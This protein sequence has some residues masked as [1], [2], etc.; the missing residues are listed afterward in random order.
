MSIRGVWVIL[1]YSDHPPSVL[2][3]RR[4]PNIE[5]RALKYSSKPFPHFPVPSDKDMCNAVMQEVGSVRENDLSQTTIRSCDKNWSKPV[6]ELFEGRLWPVVLI[7]QKNIYFVT[8]P[9][10]QHK[11][12]EE[13]PIPIEIPSIPV[14]LELLISMAQILSNSP[15]K[16]KV[17]GPFLSSLHQFLSISVPMGTILETNVNT[18]SSYVPVL[19]EQTLP[20][21]LPDL[22]SWK[23]VVFKGNPK[24]TLKIAEKVQL[25]QW[26][27][28]RS[29]TFWNTY[30]TV[31]CKTELEGVPEI[32]L[33]LV[34]PQG[35]FGLRTIH[36]HPSV[37][38]FDAQASTPDPEETN[39]ITLQGPL[40]LAHTTSSTKIRFSPPL[41]WFTVCEYSCSERNLPVHS[42]FAPI[43]A[44]YEM[45]GT[46]KLEFYIHLKLD[47]RVRNNFEYLEITIP[48]FN[49]GP[50]QTADIR[51]ASMQ[52][53]ISSD[54]RRLIWNVDKKF[55]K[56]L[57]QTLQATVT[58]PEDP[59]ESVPGEDPLCTG[60]TAYILINFRILD[61]T[62]SGIVIEPRSVVSFPQSKYKLVINRELSSAEYK[63]WNVNG[64][65]VIPQLAQ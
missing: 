4:Y 11:L 48:L 18:Y 42:D 32:T 36:T 53:S 49:R 24:L 30:G 8:L 47:E 25:T 28:T 33:N 12:S 29:T 21:Q 9:L 13:R 37:H 27:L 5:R 7:Q 2:Y 64:D 44:Y 63:I 65:T 59:G 54:Q 26:D 39:S 22:P 50:I 34:I 31:Q 6:Y 60:L 38:M 52:V 19:T 57:E 1:D 56:N 15:E 61:F 20:S 45:K 51:P 35:G 17:D 14:A 55:P 62:I 16:I 58:F 46:H 23:P 41:G 10:S 3:S 40:M 43:K